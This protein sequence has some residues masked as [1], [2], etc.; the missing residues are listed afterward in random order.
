[1]GVAHGTRNPA[2]VDAV[3]QIV[4]ALRRFS[5]SL[6][7]RAAFIEFVEHWS[8]PEFAD[9]VAALG[10]LAAPDKHEDLVGDV[11]TLEVAFWD[12]ALSVE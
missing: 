1:M 10:E 7:V 9:Y 6:E 3:L 12:M 4:D 5:P 8:T 11:L 2:G